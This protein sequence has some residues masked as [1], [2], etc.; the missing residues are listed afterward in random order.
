MWY[1]IKAFFSVWSGKSG[2]LYTFVSPFIALLVS[3]WKYFRTTSRTRVFLSFVNP[4]NRSA[5][6]NLTL[7]RVL[8][9]ELYNFERL[10]K[11]IQRTCTSHNKGKD[12]ED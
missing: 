10:Y 8:Q 5:R 12:T 11:F 3:A 9:K 1:K 2:V 6:S 4:F 7:Y